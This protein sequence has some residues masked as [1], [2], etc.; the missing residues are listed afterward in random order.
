MSIIT[1][2]HI[3]VLYVVIASL[4]LCLFVATNSLLSQKT[5]IQCPS[6]SRQLDEVFATTYQL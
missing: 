4:S 6:E 5:S 1:S 3:T 2:I